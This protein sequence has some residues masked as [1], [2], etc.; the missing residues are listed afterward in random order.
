MHFL[1]HNRTWITG[2]VRPEVSSESN[3]EKRWTKEIGKLFASLPKDYPQARKAVGELSHSFHRGLADAIGPGFNAHLQTMPHD[4]YEEKQAI[5]S[6]CNHELRN[7][8]L[9]IR[10]PR[11]H[12]PAILLADLRG[13]DDGASRF[14]LEIRDERGRKIRTYSS[15][16]LPAVDLMEDPPRREG[17][18]R[19]WRDIEDEQRER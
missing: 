14:R 3:K 9:A 12:R 4:T 7:L 10:C 18:S 19:R 13:H 17:L 11:T 5:S 15:S 2:R 16:E 1:I 6:W 8:R